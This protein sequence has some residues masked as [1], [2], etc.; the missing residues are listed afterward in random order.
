M[1]SEE[2]DVSYKRKRT[3]KGSVFCYRS[4]KPALQGDQKAY[5]AEKMKRDKLPS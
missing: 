3:L 4:W 2:G 5:F 1:F